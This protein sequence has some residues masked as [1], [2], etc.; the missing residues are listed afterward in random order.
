LNTVA[1]T[2]GGANASGSTSNDVNVDSTNG[3]LPLLVE[4]ERRH[5]VEAAT[6]RIMKARKQLQHNDLIAEVTK[7]LSSRFIPSPQ[8]I[9]KRIEGLIER[10][11]IERAE[12][13]HR[14]YTYVA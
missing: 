6:V 14:M 1:K 11:Y 10:E 12:D 7:Q 8:F 4:E 9:K 3:A 13:D 2:P 5:L